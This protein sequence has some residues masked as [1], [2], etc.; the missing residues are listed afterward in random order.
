MATYAVVNEENIVINVIKIA[1]EDVEDSN[2]NEIPDKVLEKKNELLG[3]EFNA[4]LIKTSYNNNSNRGLY[5]GIG[6]TYSDELD[7]FIRPKDIDYFVLDEKTGT[8]IPPQP[9]PERTQYQIDNDIVYRWDDTK[10]QNGQIPWE[11]DYSGVD[12]PPQPT[13]EEKERGCIY[14]WDHESYVEGDVLSGFVLICPL[15]PPTI[16]GQEQ[17]SSTTI[18]PRPELTAEEIERGCYY[19]WSPSGFVLECP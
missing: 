6:F 11:L 2:G 15:E 16:P 12:Y 18:D 17:D 10:Y 4:R 9:E 1:D 19:N 8:W 7:L 14:S 5:V 13:D 3:E